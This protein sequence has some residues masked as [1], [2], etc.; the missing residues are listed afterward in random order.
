MILISLTRKSDGKKILVNP[1]NVFAIY[2]YHE[3]TTVVQSI[4][5]ENNYV[6][7]V[8]SVESIEK[9][10]WNTERFNNDTVGD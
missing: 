5:D 10:I 9:I 1:K 8:E 4:G 7:V 3:D 2:P 6:T